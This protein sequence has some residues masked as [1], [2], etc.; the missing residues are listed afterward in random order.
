MPL[1][2]G[3]KEFRNVDDLEPLLGP[4]CGDIGPHGGGDDHGVP[5]LSLS[6]KRHSDMLNDHIR[7]IRIRRYGLRFHQ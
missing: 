1:A 3:K 5:I 2:K 4:R 6:D 7:H